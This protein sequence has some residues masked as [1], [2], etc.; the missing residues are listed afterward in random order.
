MKFIGAFVASVAVFPFGTSAVVAVSE[1]ASG[2]SARLIASRWLTTHPDVAGSQDELAELKTENPEAYAIVKA[3]LT[4]RSLGLL[5]PKHPTASFAAPPPAAGD[6]DSVPSGAAAFAKFTSPGEVG[7][8]EKRS[9]HVSLE[10]TDVPPPSQ[11]R[12]W[13]S[14]KPSSSAMEDDAAV[15]SVLGEVAALKPARVDTH[16]SAS[17]QAV[18][19]V[20]APQLRGAEV[21]AGTSVSQ[22][23]AL[24]SFSWTSDEHAQQA[25]Q[26]AETAKPA[27]TSAKVSVLSAWLTGGTTATKKQPEAAPVPTKAADVNPYTAGLW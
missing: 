14:W 19:A 13:L 18:D 25:S 7:G 4:K 20:P 23:N 3:L 1:V 8:E 12:D 24:A 22:S 9:T 2:A 10:Y 15:Q 17:L 6:G 11:H 21:G 5:D 26:P 16:A 27:Q